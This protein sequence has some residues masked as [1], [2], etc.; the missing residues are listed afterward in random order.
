MRVMTTTDHK[1]GLI[2]GCSPVSLRAFGE[3]ADC[4]S[5]TLAAVRMSVTQSAV[6]HH[7]KMLEQQLNVKLFERRGRRLLLTNEGRLLYQAVKTAFDQLSFAIESIHA[8]SVRRRVVLGVLASFATKWLLPRL[9]GFYRAHPDI[10]LVVR[11]VNH[12]IDVSSEQVDLAVVTLPGPPAAAAV[13][14][15]LM[16]RERLF[17][18]C[19]PS[20]MRQ[21]ATPRLKTVEDLSHHVLLHDE[22]EIAAERGFDWLSWLRHYHLETIMRTAVSQ[23]FSQSDLT[24]QAAMAGHG[25]ALT[26]TSIAAT[27]IKN[28]TLVNPFPE[29][30][31][32]T[33][34]ACYLCGD[35][36]R[37]DKEANRRLRDWLLAEAA[38]D[39]T[40]WRTDKR[41]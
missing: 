11:S 20:Y 2:G 13:K 25:I 19:S 35:T 22:T 6:S 30:E 7:I 37:W 27:D 5:F 31:W 1:G 29:N 15:A 34:S 26:R 41:A 32:L 8:G 4:G 39:Q 28:G 24:L 10:E 17:P 12:T 16:W 14:S 36:S 3:A 33:Q 18:V 23:Y 40:F 21:H 38:A 9:G